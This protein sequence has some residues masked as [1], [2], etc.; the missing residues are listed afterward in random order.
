MDIE[1]AV[2]ILDVAADRVLGDAEPFCDASIR[3]A[4][5]EKSYDVDLAGRQRGIH[6]YLPSCWRFIY[7]RGC[8][9]A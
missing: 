4:L 3:A 6:G 1:L 2:E 7:C 9:S 8:A 5:G